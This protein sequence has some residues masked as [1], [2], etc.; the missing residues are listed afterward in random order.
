MKDN[1]SY[2]HF[3]SYEKI[4]EPTTKAIRGEEG[5]EWGKRKEDGKDIWNIESET[6]ISS[7]IPL[8]SSS[9]SLSDK[10]RITEKSGVIK[11]DGDSG[12]ETCIINEELEK[13]YYC[14]Y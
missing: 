5:M 12:N 1:F 6:M 8:S 14:Y 7:I 11:H 10:V 9:F 3:I 2:V 13:V 4:K